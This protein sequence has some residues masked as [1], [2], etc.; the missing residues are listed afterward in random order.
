MTL[1]SHSVPDLSSVAHARVWRDGVYVDDEITPE[2]L[3]TL[4]KD[5]SCL[6]W[7][8]LV[9]PSPAV[10]TAIT[11]RFGLPAT[12]VED[13]LAPHERAKITRHDSHVFFTV[14]ATQLSPSSTPGRRN[15]NPPDR[16]T[17][18]R[19]S[20]IVLPMALVTIRLD[21]CLNTDELI[22][23]WDENADLLRLGSSALVYGLLDY[24][25]DGHFDTIQSIDDELERLED[26]LFAEHRTDSTFQRDVFALRKDL[27]QLRRVVLPMREVVSGV[28]RHTPPAEGLT[29]WYDD[30]VDHVLRASEWTES[31]RD[32][33]TS[34]FET[35][36][37]LQEARLNT[38]MR[39][40][41][42]WAAIIAVP[43]LITGW[44]GQNLPY[45]GF[46]QPG[47]VAVSVA[48]IAV[49]VGVL[50]TFFRKWKWI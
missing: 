14:Y 39:K 2:N 1:A 22:A 30:L 15:A 23:R 18:S 32:L 17:T 7:I 36:L 13:A 20:G 9:N 27:V 4:A 21:D 24:V 42:A 41:A 19:V 26:V 6:V 16:L 38:I 40:L 33:V 44:Y 46:N 8:D 5:P 28:L 31:L 37:S 12:A 48:L 43:T 10:L 29:T 34:I 47:G 45:P 3:V 35:N 11:Q 25:V 49:S 50:F